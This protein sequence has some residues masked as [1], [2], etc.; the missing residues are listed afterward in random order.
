MVE[1]Q[2]RVNQWLLCD[3]HIHTSSWSDGEVPLHEVVDLYGKSGFDVISI[4]DHVLDTELRRSDASYCIDPS[5]FDKYLEELWREARRAWDVFRMILLPGTEVTNQTRKYHILAV[6]I[7]RY[8][9]PDD[10][11]EE[12]IEEIHRQGGIAIACHPHRKDSEGEQAVDNSH[13]LWRNH[14]RYAGLFDA[15]EVAN[16]DDLF[17]V[18]GLKKFNYVANGDFHSRRHLYSWKTLLNCPKNAEAVKQAI[19]DNVGVSLHLLREKNLSP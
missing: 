5:E 1:L 17:N 8:I 14:E 15:W 3:F 18:V 11:V 19:R 12:I 6:D 7:K 13:Y 10:A 9:H 2:R 4:T 16:R